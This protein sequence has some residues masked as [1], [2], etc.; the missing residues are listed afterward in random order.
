MTNYRGKAVVANYPR[1]ARLQSNARVE[2]V[3]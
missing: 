3:V 2:L 1:I